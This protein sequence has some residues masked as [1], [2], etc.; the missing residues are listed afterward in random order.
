ML[1]GGGKASHHYMPDASTQP[2]VYFLVDLEGNFLVGYVGSFERLTQDFREICHRIG[3]A[4]S[5]GLP[6]APGPGENDYCS[7]YS[8]AAAELLGLRNARTSRLRVFL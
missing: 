4:D 2:Q 1:E 5:I 6:P 8:Q 7:C 3:I